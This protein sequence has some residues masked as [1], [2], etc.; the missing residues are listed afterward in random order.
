M[1][2]QSKTRRRKAVAKTV[3]ARHHSE[4]KMAAEKFPD[5]SVKV[6]YKTW[7]RERR[8]AEQKAAA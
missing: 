7:R 4:R 5:M 3:T 6:A 8:S 2:R 1:S